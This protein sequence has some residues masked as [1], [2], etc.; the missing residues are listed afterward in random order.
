MNHVTVAPRHK[1]PLF[2]EYLSFRATD[3]TLHQPQDLHNGAEICYCQLSFLD[4]SRA[5]N[6]TQFVVRFL[7]FTHNLASQAFLVRGEK[8]PRATAIQLTQEK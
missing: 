6:E 3:Q 1:F 4:R 5:R 7:H 2:T 8:C